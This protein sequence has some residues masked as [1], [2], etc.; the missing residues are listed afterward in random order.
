MIIITWFEQNKRKKN[1]NKNN[2]DYVKQKNVN[3][4]YMAFGCGQFPINVLQSDGK[5]QLTVEQNSC[6]KNQ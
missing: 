6:N 3:L 5:I 1:E 2:D 4:K